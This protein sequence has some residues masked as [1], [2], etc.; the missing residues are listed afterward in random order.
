MPLFII[1][2]F[3]AIILGAGAMLAPAWPTLHPRIGLSAALALAIIMGGAIVWSMLFG[4]DTL[5]VDYLLFV[6]VTSIFLGGTLSI[7]Q[8]RAEERGETLAQAEA[9][10]GW[11]SLRDL[12]LFGLV[13]ILFILP[14][15][16]LPVPL[17]T[18][19]Q[20]FGYL[21]LMTRLGGTFDTLAPFNPDVTYLYAPGLT[22]LSAYLSHRLGQ[23]LPD[24]QFSLGAVFS[25]VLV[26]LAYD[27]GSEYRDKRLGRAMAVA[28]VGGI[29]LLTAYMDSHYTSLLALVFALAFLTYVLRYTRHQLPGDAVAAA[30]LLGAVVLAHPDTTIIL[31]LGYV[32]WLGLMWL[33]KQRPT[34]RTWLVLAAG[35]PLFAL[36]LLL[37]WLLN[38]RQLLG[39]DIVSPFARNPDY[40][41]V[42]VLYHGVWIVPVA[43]IGAV[44]GLRQRDSIVLLCVGWL[45]MILEFAA[46][47]VLETLA[48]WLIAPIVRYD[49]PFSIAWHGPII[50]YAILGGIGLLWL[51]DRLIEPRFGRV[52]HQLLPYALAAGCVL[53]LVGGAFSTSLL[54]WSK[55]RVG[56]FGAFAS[57]A[58]VQAMDWLR[59]NAEPDARILNF[60]GPQEGDWVP[61]IA[62]RESVYYRPQ[63]F[64]RGDDEDLAEQ[65]RLRAFWEDPANPD[66]EIL[67]TEAGIDYV[68]VPQV[69]TDPASIARMFRWR[70]PFTEAITMQSSVADAPY[71]TPVFDAD[72]AQVYKLAA[73]ETP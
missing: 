29:G 21:G 62:E 32:P 26:W 7:G 61:V 5:A 22:A 47:G 45:V 18:D 25:F 66:N 58:D 12:L 53:L 56:F 70:A 31:I 46:L 50:P 71:L 38:I 34:L 73:G 40:W 64:F 57:H 19:A 6:L 24:V 17:D 14:V 13:A 49:Y 59:L 65:E 72:G 39:S 35:I 11:T 20:G 52:I 28:M 48:P 3:G 54:E 30:L 36:V 68:I 37:P 23:T 2:V 67:L 60:P 42:M 10:A 43:L 44:R 51:W 55:G 4:W 9:D 63:P 1:F 33:S 27:F 15:V 16:I 41:R 69:V 8:K